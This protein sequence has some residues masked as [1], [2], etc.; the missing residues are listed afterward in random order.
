MSEGEATSVLTAAG[1]NV[2]IVSVD[3]TNEA[4]NGVVLSSS[5]G[6]QQTPG[7]TITLSVGVWD[8]STG[9]ATTT[10]TTTTPETT[11]TTPGG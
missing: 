5:P 1:F 11:T 6:G 2:E 3:T 9:T 8:G 4:Q 7:A 10:T